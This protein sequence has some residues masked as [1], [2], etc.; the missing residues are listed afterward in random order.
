MPDSE[1]NEIVEFLKK[2]ASFTEEVLMDGDQRFGYAASELNSLA[3]NL[4]DRVACYSVEPY[5]T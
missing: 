3:H 2:V 4:A 5:A 1:R